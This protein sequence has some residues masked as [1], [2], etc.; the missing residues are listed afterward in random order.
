[1]RPVVIPALAVILTPV[2]GQE[3]ARTDTAKPYE[4]IVVVKVDSSLT[5]DELYPVAKRWF[6][7]VFRDADEVIQIDDPQRHTIVGK[8][9]FTFIAS[10]LVASAVRKGIMR[11]SV[12]VIVK[13]GRYR[14]RFYDYRHEGTHA[15]SP[16]LAPPLDLG[17]IYNDQAYC[18]HNYNLKDN[19][20][21]KPSK[22]EVRVCME[23]VWPQIAENESSLLSVLFKAMTAA[24]AGGSKG[25]V[26][27]VSDW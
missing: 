20:S 15:Y 21:Y 22:H 5:A 10:I 4:R 12:E 7:D 16:Y 14:V 23:E 26:K 9:N 2:L 6:V 19:P 1:M 11:F 8:G 24:A 27:G 25:G 3:P 17:L 13:N 18:T